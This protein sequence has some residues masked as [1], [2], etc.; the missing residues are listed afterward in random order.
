MCVRD[1]TRR[2]GHLCISERLQVLHEARNGFF[3]SRER[4]CP[5]R[6]GLCRGIVQ[7]KTRH[8]DSQLASVDEHAVKEA[9]KGRVEGG[10]GA[11]VGHIAGGGGEE[12]SGG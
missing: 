11:H 2:C 5:S 1:D 3:G 4:C 9:G 10:V 12:T 6:G 8:R 7:S